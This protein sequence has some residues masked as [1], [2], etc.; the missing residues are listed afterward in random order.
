[1][2]LIFS[3]SIQFPDSN[4]LHSVAQN[5]I[6]S[7]TPHPPPPHPFSGPARPVVFFLLEGMKNIHAPN[8]GSCLICYEREI[9]NA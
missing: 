7:P 8:R 3:K 9:L 2:D 1:M 5:T 6:P 4:T